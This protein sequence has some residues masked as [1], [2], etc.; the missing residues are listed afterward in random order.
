MKILRIPILRPQDNPIL[1]GRL[2]GKRLFLRV[3]EEIPPLKEMALVVMD[4]AGVDLVTSSFLSEALMPLR[5]HLRSRRPPGYVV[6]ANLKSKVRE[7]L[8]EFLTRSGDALLTCEFGE[9]DNA[10]KIELS[11]MLEPKLLETWELVRSKGETSAVELHG[12]TE[13]DGIGPTAWNNRLA[14][15]ASKSLVIELPQG[16]SKKYRSIVEMA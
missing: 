14:A 3:L 13:S 5:E 6:A 4:F 11:G 10:T 12:I 7:E 8:D 1:A 9:G 15:L 16:R 2:D